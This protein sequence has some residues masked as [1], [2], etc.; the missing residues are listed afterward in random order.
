[1][2][3]T[4][5]VFRNVALVPILFVGCEVGLTDS[6][7]AGVADLEPFKAALLVPLV[8]KVNSADSPPDPYV[9]CAGL[10]PCE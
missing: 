7:L 4:L 10:W 8:I 9:I 3:A 5:G 6:P 2:S 1:M